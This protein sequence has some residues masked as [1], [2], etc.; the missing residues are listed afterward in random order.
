MIPAFTI[1]MLG[2]C[3]NGRSMARYFEEVASHYLRTF[4]RVR[5]AEI[6]GQVGYFEHRGV[7]AWPPVAGTS[8]ADLELSILSLFVILYVRFSPEM[9]P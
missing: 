3:A 4:P 1:G 6:F 5:Y 2:G 8:K 9:R 7:H